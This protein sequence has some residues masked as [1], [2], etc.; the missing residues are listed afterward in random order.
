MASFLET[1]LP[2]EAVTDAMTI[3]KAWANAVARLMARFDL[4]LTPTLPVTAFAA[5]R[6]GPATIDGLAVGPDEW[7]PFTS[8]FNLTGQP[9]VSVFAGLVEGLPVG[10][11]IV[12]P[13]LGD[14]LVLSAA[15]AFEALRPAPRPP[16]AL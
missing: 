14:G 6:E 2:L 1:R 7:A 16:F 5:E 11:Q 3:R 4:I 8:P 12:G 9:A 10:L 15:A 13:H